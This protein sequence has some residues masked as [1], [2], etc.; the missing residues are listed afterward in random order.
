MR[1]RTL[2]LA[3]LALATGLAATAQSFTPY[4]AGTADIYA[5]AKANYPSG[6]YNN[7]TT[8]VLNDLEDHNW[9]LYSD[10]ASPIRSLYPRNVQIIYSGQ[11]KYYTQSG[12]SSTLEREQPATLT[13]DFADLTSAAHHQVGIGSVGDER[14]ANRL[15]Y[16]KT[17]E[18]G[19]PFPSQ[20][21]FA[22]R[23][24]ANPFSRRP[25]RLAA[26]TITPQAAVRDAI[27]LGF[28]R[29]R[30]K[31]V[32]GGSIYTQE[33]GGSPLA[34]GDFVKADQLLWYQPT[35]NSQ[36]NANNEL[37]MAVEFEAVWTRAYLLYTG[38][39]VPKVPTDKLA[40]MRGGSPELNF[41]VYKYNGTNVVQA[42]V[43][44]VPVTYSG[45]FPNGTTDGTTAFAGT[46]PDAQASL[47]FQA[48]RLSHPMRLEYLKVQGNALRFMARGKS[49]T[50][51]RG[52]QFTDDDKGIFFF[53][54][55][56]SYDLN[57]DLTG[58]NAPFFRF[59]GG[60]FNEMHLLGSK[61][62]DRSEV[63]MKAQFGNDYDRAL[64]DNN[65]LVITNQIM[66][67]RAL[68]FASYNTDRNRML[69]DMVFKSGTHR[70]QRDQASN[71]GLPQS[72]TRRSIYCGS[73]RGTSLNGVK[74]GH[75]VLVV[76]GGYL[77]DIL[78][79]RTGFNN[80]NRPDDGYPDIYIRLRGGYAKGYIGGAAQHIKG[81]GDPMIVCTGGTVDGYIAAGANATYT[82]NDYGAGNNEDVAHTGNVVGHSRVYVGGNFTVSMATQ[83]TLMMSETGS[84]YGSGCG[85]DYGDPAINAKR[86]FGEVDNATVVVA[87]NV[88]VQRDVYGGGRTGNVKPGGT[89]TIYIAGGTVNGKVFGSGRQNKNGHG[90]VDLLMVNGLVK[91]G[92]HGGSDRAGLVSGNISV[93]IEGGTVGYDGCTEEYGNVFGC[94]YGEATR[95]TGDVRVTIGK[96]AGKFPHISTPLIH[97]NVYCGGYMGSYT[98]TNNTFRIKTWN[99]HIKN[100]VYG[101]GCGTTAVITGDTRVQVMGT[102]RVDRN[103]YG[104][105]NM[106][107]VV[108]NTHVQI[109]D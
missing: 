20:N 106:G 50:F 73:E 7:K 78:G 98:S 1:K 45:I 23:A 107:K 46:L 56:D 66:G 19:W 97:Q 26:G 72:T 82:P 15:V 42:G 88:N 60:R 41:V 90:N 94:G 9:T 10:T 14:S 77:T 91:G 53:A 39:E 69:M 30:L 86:S 109:G 11:G 75:R 80:D 100:S 21:R 32:A 49:V 12:A 59:E 81:G 16:L 18:R 5:A 64:A 13:A 47:K 33:S 62:S 52:L 58:A 85:Y 71:L 79:G 93:R 104:G 28:Y 76:E 34:V 101:G 67:G 74:L 63:E 65:K 40:D 2:V 44:D 25:T 99:G 89:A 3:L 27:W 108:G 48:F 92:I 24:I 8:V 57:L 17:L 95:V 70:M 55:D 4:T 83:D 87:D 43:P 37:S 35:N 38:E 105:G 51:G 96:E 29:W 22:C 61:A 68:V 102:T 54:L 36:T 103:V 84:I 31:S 6:V